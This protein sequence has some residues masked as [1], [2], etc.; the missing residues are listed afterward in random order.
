MAPSRNVRPRTGAD[1]D[2]CVRVL[3]D[4]R[5]VDGH[6]V[7]WPADPPSWLSPPRLHRAWVAGPGGSVVGHA[8]PGTPADGSM[9]LSRLSVTPHA[10]RSG[11]VRR[12]GRARMA[13]WA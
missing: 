3:A 7:N 2:A 4:V 5:R 1:L 11:G 12:P 10:G 9:E 6:P 8:V 13:P